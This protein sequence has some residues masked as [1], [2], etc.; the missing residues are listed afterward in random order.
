MAPEGC[1][2]AAAIAR[3]KSADA[4]IVIHCGDVIGKG[5]TSVA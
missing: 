4:H 2:L 5:H 1:P 3:G